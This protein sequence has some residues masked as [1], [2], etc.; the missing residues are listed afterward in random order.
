[1][2]LILKL[3]YCAGKNIGKCH[4]ILRPSP[5]NNLVNVCSYP[6][7]CLKSPSKLSF[8]PLN[9]QVYN[10][11][12]ILSKNGAYVNEI[13]WVFN[14]KSVGCW[15]LFWFHVTVLFPLFAWHES[16]CDRQRTYWCRHFFSL[17]TTFW[18]LQRDLDIRVDISSRNI[19][20]LHVI[21]RWLLAGYFG[22]ALINISGKCKLLQYDLISDKKWKW[23]KQ[24]VL[25]SWY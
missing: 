16:M 24:C 17:F 7:N 5:D 15:Q 10:I 18:W 12:S 8:K 22:L 11:V 3:R 20:L 2:V 1:M 14:V 19:F 23:C 6:T 4:I 25:Q 9:I 13:G 21:M